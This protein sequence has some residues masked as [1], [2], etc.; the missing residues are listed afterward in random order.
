MRD[1]GGNSGGGGLPSSPIR[2]CAFIPSLGPGGAERVMTGLCGHL[3]EAKYDVTLATLDA[4]GSASFYP[5][6]PRVQT[7]GMGALG[8]LRRWDRLGRIGGR[9]V[10]IRRLVR[11]ARPDVILSFMDTM[12]VTVLLATCG[13]RVPVIVSER[14]D[15]SAHRHRI[16]RFKS[17]L[18]R[19]TYAW[20][21]RVVVQTRRA[22][23]FFP[24]LPD[25]RVCI[26]ANPVT[27]PETAAVPERAGQDQRFRIIGVGRLDPQKGF[28]LLIDA[29]ARLAADFPEWDVVIFG[30]GA[31]RP[32]LSAR[33]ARH[34]LAERI[35]LPG[36]TATVDAEYDRA[37]IL[38]FPS[39]Y[40]GF[41]NAFAEGMAAGLPA[42]A[43]EGVSG[44]EDLAVPGQTALL[45]PTGDVCV[46]A[47]Q[48]AVLMADPDRRRRLGEAARQRIGDYSPATIYGA[49][50]RLM[51]EVAPT[52]WY[53]GD[54]VRGHEAGDDQLFHR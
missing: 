40:E 31:E 30:E 45:A 9:F 46:F 35:R 4:P 21:A 18:R 38:A 39:R 13:L 15:P 12:N 26:L 44:V 54:E 17:A 2:V 8:G 32:A 11:Q 1:C 33:I 7:V 24:N 43:F 36:V 19:L 14:V 48:L 53:G 3:V 29:F 28:E 52:P 22:R 25:R 10:K 34:G 50:R 27:R 23:A 6:D 37:H 47:A 16:G 51:G 42:V 5:L 20:A 49:W 41:P